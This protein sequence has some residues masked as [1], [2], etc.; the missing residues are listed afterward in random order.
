MHLRLQCHSETPSL[1]QPSTVGYDSIRA[2]RPNHYRARIG[3]LGSPHQS[4]VG[5][6][7]YC[8]D[9]S[10]VE[11]LSTGAGGLLKDQV[12]ELVPHHR[13]AYGLSKVYGNWGPASPSAHPAGYSVLELLSKISGVLAKHNI[14]IASVIQKEEN[15][16][17]VPVIIMTHKCSEQGML[18]SV[19]TINSFEFIEC[20]VNLIKVEDY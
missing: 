6:E 10:S 20:D 7:F 3:A 14:S 13:P 16:K 15:T 18:Q 17:Y 12:V 5:E 4:R 11:N 2:V 9:P 8:I 19:K 1:H